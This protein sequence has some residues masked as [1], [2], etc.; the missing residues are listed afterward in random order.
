[1]GSIT[2]ASYVAPNQRYTTGFSGQAQGSSSPSSASTSSTT[3][4]F[5]EPVP[6]NDDH[7]SRYRAS[8]H[9]FAGQPYSG[10]NRN[11]M[12]MNGTSA[13][14]IEDLTSSFA[15]FEPVE[16]G[17]ERELR[18]ELKSTLMMPPPAFPRHNTAVGNQTGSVAMPVNGNKQSV[19]TIA[20]PSS[21]TSSSYYQPGQA[22]LTNG[23]P[24]SNSLDQGDYAYA[25]RQ[26]HA[27]EVPPNTPQETPARSPERAERGLAAH[28]HYAHQEASSG[29]MPG[30]QYDETG[31]KDEHMSSD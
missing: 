28:M 8:P 16:S 29:R 11:D 3:A 9:R 10:T 4:T 22:S 2:V 6:G 26:S 31:S 1:M 17:A 20:P 7:L 24:S 19:G 21:Y 27:I 13:L 5:G 14:S 18:R 15:G 12:S 23:L 25:M 30:D